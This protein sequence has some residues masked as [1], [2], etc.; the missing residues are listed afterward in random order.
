MA[1][2]PKDG[3][4]AQTPPDASHE[5]QPAGATPEPGNV[6]GLLAKNK[7]LLGELK[8]WKT[9]ATAADSAAEK[10]KEAKLKEDGKLKELLD[11]RTAEAEAKTSRIRRA[12]LKAVAV[13]NGLVDMDYIDILIGKVEFDENDTPTNVEDVFKDLREKKPYLF[14][15]PE[16]PPPPGTVNKN[17]AGWKP[18]GKSLTLSEVKAMSP[19]DVL[20]NQ[21]QI[22]KQAFT[23][24]SK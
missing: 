18:G 16:T 1:D 14:K 6:E 22:L 11:K 7:E 10:E 17:A 9:K 4:A 21:D 2:E 13:Q 3:A 15:Q 24:I 23:G 8:K 5:G 20:K 12:E 19:E